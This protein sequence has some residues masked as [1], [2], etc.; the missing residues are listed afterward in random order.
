[1]ILK[2]YEKCLDIE[3]IDYI[4][5]SLIFYGIKIYKRLIYTLTEIEISLNDLKSSI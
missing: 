5:K 3:K 4:I 2:Y 1:M